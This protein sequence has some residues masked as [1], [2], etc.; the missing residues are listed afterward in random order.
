MGESQR[1]QEQSRV[2]R[3]ASRRMFVRRAAPG[4][5][6]TEYKRYYFLSD[7]NGR[8]MMIKLWADFL[9]WAEL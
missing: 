2:D 6:P 5:Y 1:R 4:Q 3:R 7:M 9:K 8:E